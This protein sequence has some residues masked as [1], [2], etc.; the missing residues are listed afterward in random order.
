MKLVVN[1]RCEQGTP[2]GVM[3]FSPG[4]YAVAQSGQDFAVTHEVRD[5]S[6]KVNGARKIVKV[7]QTVVPKAILDK[8]VAAGVAKL[9]A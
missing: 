9:E 2:K 4:E 3:K 8:L 7:A 6:R 5:E 1:Q